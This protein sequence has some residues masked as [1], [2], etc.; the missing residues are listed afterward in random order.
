M[1]YNAQAKLFASDLSNY[2]EIRR[3]LS[4]AMRKATP[5]LKELK[6][7]DAATQQGLINA[8]NDWRQQ[9]QAQKIQASQLSKGIGSVFSSAASSGFYSTQ[10]KITLQTAGLKLRSMDKDRA[11]WE[12]RESLGA[13]GRLH[14]QDFYK[15]KYFLDGNEWAPEAA[16]NAMLEAILFSGGILEYDE[17]TIRDTIKEYVKRA[18]GVLDDLEAESQE[19]ANLTGSY[20]NDVLNIAKLF[21][22]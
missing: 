1:A 8:L 17:Q 16:T 9:G 3:G 21:T 2:S 22:I 7:V 13:T 20:Y 11:E 6:S 12:L 4:P 19:R 10:D 5:T 14:N 15:A 18:Y